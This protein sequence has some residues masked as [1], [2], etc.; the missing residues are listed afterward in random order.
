[1]KALDFRLLIPHPKFHESVHYG[2]LKQFN[3]LEPKTK[4][5]MSEEKLR[6]G[7]S[8]SEA[9]LYQLK[10][11]VCVVH[12]DIAKRS[13]IELVQT[14]CDDSAELLRV[15]EK[16]DISRLNRKINS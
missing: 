1:M 8:H 9:T 2:L 12:I 7:R 13:V 15:A 4:F 11:N 5:I 14:N 3:E 10:R 6:I 16:I